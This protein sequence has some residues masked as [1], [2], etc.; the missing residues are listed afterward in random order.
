MS[1]HNRPELSATQLKSMAAGWRVFEAEHITKT[2]PRQE[3]AAMALGSAIHAAILE[4]ERFDADYACIPPQ[5]DDK[6]T[7]AY[8]EWAA[9]HEGKIH[10]KQDDALTITILRRAFRY[11]KMASTLFKTGTAETEHFWESFGVKCRGKFDWLAGQFV[12]DIKTCQ[13]ATDKAFAKDIAQR[14]YDLQAAHYLSAGVA[15]RFIFVACETTSPFRVRCYE[16]GDA[17]LQRANE[18]R[19]NLIEEY[20]ERRS[21][22]DWHEAGENEL[23]T[24]FLPN[25]RA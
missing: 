16:L 10:L 18:D 9:A 3:S 23:R 20:T 17:D 21:R 15:D 12:V 19:Q 2:A 25:W 24:I 11:D 7:T 5:C 22:N 1:Y 14:R 8:K 4:P 6:R 13:D